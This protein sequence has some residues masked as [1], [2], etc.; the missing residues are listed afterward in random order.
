MMGALLGG[1]LAVAA[2]TMAYAVRGRS[3]NLFAPSIYK[4]SPDRRAVALTFDDGPSESTPVLLEVL[5]KYEAKATFFE[6]GMHVRRLPAVARTVAAAG[7]EIGNHTETHAALWLRAPAFI[8]RE[9]GQ[10]QQ[11]IF[12]TTGITPSLFRAPYGA[13]WFG[14]RGVQARFGLMGVMWT[15]LARDWVLPAARI[16]ARL[17]GSASNGVIF[18]LHDGREREANPDIR[19][20]IAAVREILPRLLDR[21]FQFLTVSQLLCPTT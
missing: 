10:A 17:L 14:L 6:C 20:T 9:I 21:G 12:E 2:G 11:S 1:S 15:A 16:S 8:H 7:H 3:S 19:H 13:R 4:G 5:A 18:C